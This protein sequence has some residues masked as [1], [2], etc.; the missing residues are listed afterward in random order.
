MTSLYPAD[1]VSG[2]V[3][4]FIPLTTVFTPPSSCSSIFRLDGASYMAFDPG[5]GL[6][7]DEKVICQPP[8]VTTW[9]EQDNLGNAATGHTAVSLGPLTCPQDWQTMESSVKDD[10]STAAIC[11]PS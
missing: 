9:W 7:I 6:D 1:T 3:M 4:S 11:C 10:L 2:V 5:Y 8:A